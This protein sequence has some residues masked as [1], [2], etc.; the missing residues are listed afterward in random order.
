M[1]K[2]GG[3]SVTKDIPEP[4][5]LQTAQKADSGF[6]M[7]ELLLVIVVLGIL[8]ATAIFA[9]GGVTSS[10]AQASCNSDAKTI[11]VAVAAFHDNS[12]N[13]ADPNGWPTS[14][15]QLTDPAA[16]NYGGPYLTTW[17]NGA[18]YNIY[19]GD[20]VTKDAV[21]NTTTPGEVLVGPSTA[22]GIGG[23]LNY[24]TVPNP[25]DGSSIS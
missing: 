1:A 6:T 22:S 13:T 7:I 15:A 11:E 23:A 2:K 4:R 3:T 21:G 24:D 25:C 9:L 10:A 20:G 18:H 19:L 5:R 16:D 12:K 14:A 17:P 8:A